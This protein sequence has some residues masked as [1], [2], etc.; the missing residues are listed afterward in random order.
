MTI[1]NGP[2]TLFAQDRNA[3][4]WVVLG[5][6]SRT[7]ASK[8]N[9][10]LSLGLTA[11][12]C[13]RTCGVLV[14]GIT[15]QWVQTTDGILCTELERAQDDELRNSRLELRV[16][17]YSVVFLAKKSFEKLFFYW[18]YDPRR[19]LL[20]SRDMRWSWEAVKVEDKK[21]G[22]RDWGRVVCPCLPHFEGR[23]WGQCPMGPFGVPL[24]PFCFQEVALTLRQSG[25]STFA[26]IGKFNYRDYLLFE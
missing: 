5:H 17:F 1:I 20:R 22:A 24:Q 18:T 10:F 7:W 19:E 16:S 9:S 3:A 13:G 11:V 6:S 2:I 14:P 25:S 21:L 4:D 12:M 26:F 23:S 15:L 8:K